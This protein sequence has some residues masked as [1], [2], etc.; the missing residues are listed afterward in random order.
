MKLLVRVLLRHVEPGGYFGIQIR[1]IAS[2]D[3]GIR[4]AVLIDVVYELRAVQD[5]PDAVHLNL[6]SA[7]MD[8][9]VL[10]LGLDLFVVLFEV[11]EHALRRI[12]A[13]LLVLILPLPSL[14][15][16]NALLKIILYLLK[17]VEFFDLFL[18][19]QGLVQLVEL[20]EFI[21]QFNLIG[22][23]FLHEVL[24]FVLIE[25]ILLAIVDLIIDIILAFFLVHFVHVA[26]GLQVDRRSICM[27][28][29]PLRNILL[30][31]LIALEVAGA[32]HLGID[33]RHVGHH[34]VLRLYEKLRVVELV[35]VLIQ[36]LGQ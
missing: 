6:N 29:Q 2:V 4:D 33:G 13:M 19:Q 26:V 3:E 1:E 12:Q 36:L 5:S 17:L 9:P 21:E 31:S 15:F 25:F 27:V 7:N 20:L 28:S 14:L 30:D 11:R 32:A 10:A 16:V 35:Q 24:L 22:D 8:V 34:S 18:V 23:V